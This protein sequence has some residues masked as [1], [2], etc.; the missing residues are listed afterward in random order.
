MSQRADRYR[1]RCH[2]RRNRFT[3]S[4]PPSPMFDDHVHDDGDYSLLQF[5]VNPHP[6]IASRYARPAEVGLCFHNEFWQDNQREDDHEDTRDSHRTWPR[7]EVHFRRRG[8]IRATGPAA[9]ALQ[10]RAPNY[11]IQ[12]EDMNLWPYERLDGGF[13]SQHEGGDDSDDGNISNT[14]D[15]SHGIPHVPG[16]RNKNEIFDEGDQQFED[17]LPNQHFITN[18]L[19]RYS[20]TA[21]I[22]YFLLS[23]IILAFT[24]SLQ[25]LWPS[26]VPVTGLQARHIAPELLG[27]EVNLTV[28]EDYFSIKLAYGTIS[29]AWKE[30][31]STEKAMEQNIQLKAL[32]EPF[33][34]IVD[35]CGILVKLGTT[36]DR[37]NGI[38]SPVE[39]I[40]RKRNFPHFEGLSSIRPD[41]MDWD[42]DEVDIFDSCKGYL[43]PL[44]DI[45]NEISSFME[46]GF[47]AWC[48]ESLNS[49]HLLHME[50][51]ALSRSKSCDVPP[52]GRGDQPG[53]TA[54]RYPLASLAFL[55]DLL[56]STRQSREDDSCLMKWKW[57]ASLQS[58]NF[59]EN[60][61][62]ARETMDGV[63]LGI[64]K[65][66]MLL[67]EVDEDFERITYIAEQVARE[68][69]S[70]VFHDIR[71]PLRSRVVRRL[72][73]LLEGQALEDDRRRI[74]SATDTLRSWIEEEEDVLAEEDRLRGF[75]QELLPSSGSSLFI[76][77]QEGAI[78][79]DK[80]YRNPWFQRRLRT[81]WTENQ[82]WCLYPDCPLH[83][84]DGT[85]N[86]ITL[87]L[88]VPST[89]Y[90]LERIDTFKKELIV[91]RNVWV[92]ENNFARRGCYWVPTD[93]EC[94]EDLEEEQD[95][96]HM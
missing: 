34:A 94:V 74:M 51:F 55:Q 72:K 90:L 19:I 95:S 77:G 24:R 41:T 65:V 21:V 25:Y 85:D 30:S 87:A 49:L 58:W 10:P 43:S 22:Y 2:R 78:L 4:E 31:Q 84:K 20:L 68:T 5:S 53:S 82:R 60:I 92:T 15:D 47:S 46:G 57:D 83:F 32:K 40:R 79:A 50:L 26:L 80:W 61:R 8:D 81:E 76:R 67:R 69:E 36:W 17:H 96:W 62:R 14:D 86:Q 70:A 93:G 16:Q 88:K 64:A 75:V 1:Q 7:T 33:S 42:T 6:E 27:H 59:Q 44:R 35:V 13:L 9:H 91:A 11:T 52:Q 3:L 38:H 12:C 71:S 39:W 37:E 45:N 66:R 73:K 28:F 89:E 54:E 48:F 18:P 63:R 23:I 29:H 56:N